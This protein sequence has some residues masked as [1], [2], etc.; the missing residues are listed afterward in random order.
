VSPPFITRGALP[1]T[2]AQSSRAAVSAMVEDAPRT[3]WSGVVCQTGGGK[4]VL[5]QAVTRNGR[6][7]E[8]KRNSMDP[9]EL[10][11]GTHQRSDHA[12]LQ[13]T[14]LLGGPRCAS[15]MLPRLSKAIIVP[16]DLSVC[17]DNVAL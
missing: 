7:T 8:K 6:K 10:E 3:K 12:G 17:A 4:P 11:A 1:N 9:N 14:C 16:G 15:K 2:A 13:G 5:C